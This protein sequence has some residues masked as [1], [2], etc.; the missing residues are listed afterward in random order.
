VRLVEEN[1]TEYKIRL[2]CSS[3]EHGRFL[4][5]CEEGWCTPI[6]FLQSIAMISQ[7]NLLT[8]YSDNSKIP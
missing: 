4:K 7:I 8:I 1:I 6:N 2:G 3:E 5:G